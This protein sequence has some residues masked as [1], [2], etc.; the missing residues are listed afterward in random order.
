[1]HRWIRKHI[2]FEDLKFTD[3]GPERRV[4]Q[5][6]RRLPQSSQAHTLHLLRLLPGDFYLSFPFPLCII[7]GQK[8]AP[9]NQMK[10]KSEV[11]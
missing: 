3:G 9:Q 2:L 8:R 1:M 7:F 5:L 10:T 11:L 4:P 6:L